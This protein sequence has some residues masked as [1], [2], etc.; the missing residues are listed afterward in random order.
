M[1]YMGG[2]WRQGP[3]IAEFVSKLIRPG[4]TYYEPFCGAMGAAFRA[5]PVC[6]AAGARGVVLSDY[7]VP[8]INMW[9][10]AMSGWVPPDVV[11]QET[12]DDVKRERET[13]RTR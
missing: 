1:N 9:R 5:A 8:L 7:S 4:M 11:S 3:K 13:R 12:Y 2:K 6:V 10:A